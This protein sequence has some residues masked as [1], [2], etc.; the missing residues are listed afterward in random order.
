[1]A[2]DV[3]LAVRVLLELAEK[4]LAFVWP[5]A[6]ARASDEPWPTAPRLIDPHVLRR[7]RRELTSTNRLARRTEATRG[8]REITTFHPF[9]TTHRERAI[10]DAA[11]RKRLVYTRYRT[12]AEGTITD[13]GGI[14]GPAAELVFHMS[15]RDAS[16]LVGYQIVNPENGQ[17]HEVL[18]EEVASGPFDNAAYAYLGDPPV[19]VTFVFESKSRRGQIYWDQPHLYQVLYKAAVLQRAVPSARIVPVLVCR[20]A[21][22]TTFRMCKDIGAY[23][24]DARRQWL[25]PYSRVTEEDL[26]EVR[27][28]LNFLDLY[29][30][31]EPWVDKRVRDHL[32]EFLPAVALRQADRWRSAGARFHEQYWNLW[33]GGP[34]TSLAEIRESMQSEHWF[35]GGW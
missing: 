27:N 25:L 29:L 11:A 16:P 24:I 20:R 13:P 35:E 32:A 2:V 5:E 18:G 3:D 22:I 26:R 17:A 10:D 23:V 21:H 4:E 7:A 28:S 1:M 31:S 34:L 19:R 6:E 15:L 12:W 9:E 30:G 33:Q 14:I 8:G